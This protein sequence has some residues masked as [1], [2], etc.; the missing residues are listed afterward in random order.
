[1]FPQYTKY[2][3]INGKSN[4][5]ACLRRAAA[6]HTSEWT[7]PAGCEISFRFRDQNIS[8]ISE[9]DYCG[10]LLST[11]YSSQRGTHSCRTC[12]VWLIVKK[13]LVQKMAFA[14][15]TSGSYVVGAIVVVLGIIVP[16]TVMVGVWRGSCWREYAWTLGFGYIFNANH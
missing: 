13:A 2:H 14:P 7:L 12:G 1:M 16:L 8:L 11:S 15:P 3:T 9:S 6:L 10:A 5:S 4:L